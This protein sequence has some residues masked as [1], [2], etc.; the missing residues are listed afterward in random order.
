MEGRTAIVIA[1]RLSTI[2]SMDTIIGLKN[3]RVVEQGSPAELA[4]STG[5]YASLLELQNLDSASAKKRLLNYEIK[6]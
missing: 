2:Q 1:H 4:K 3:G 5:I 6:A